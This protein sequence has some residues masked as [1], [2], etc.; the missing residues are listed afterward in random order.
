MENKKKNIKPEETHVTPCSTI[1][2]EMLA[3]KSLPG[4]KKENS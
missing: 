2:E 4:Q 3:A 1:A